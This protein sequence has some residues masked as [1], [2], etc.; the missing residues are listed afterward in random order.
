MKIPARAR[1]KVRFLTGG[2]GE[3]GWVQ[4]ET[5]E[6][7][8]A[9][10]RRRRVGKPRRAGWLALKRMPGTGSN[11]G[12][13]CIKDGAAAAEEFLFLAEKE[14]KQREKRFGRDA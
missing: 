4:E 13:C 12:E 14:T 10:Q 11:Y 5:E 8:K 3:P 9:E 7:G 1:V 6:R 2:R